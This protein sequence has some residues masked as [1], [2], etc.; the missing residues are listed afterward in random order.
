M[1]NLSKQN[2]DLATQREARLQNGS[3]SSGNKLTYSEAS[4]RG[5]PL[6]LVGMTEEEVVKSFYDTKPP[7]WFVDKVNSE[8]KQTVSPDAVQALWDT[9]SQKYLTGAKES[10]DHAKAVSYFKQ[11]FGE[12]ISAQDI[13]DYADAVDNYMAAGLSYRDA[14]LKVDPTAGQ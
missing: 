9:Q 1:P 10:A 3:G 2:F 14:L 5:L 7:K 13:Q 8:H 12:D 4:S 6:S 11:N